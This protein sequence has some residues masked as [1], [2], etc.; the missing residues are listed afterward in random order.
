MVSAFAGC[1]R[2]C[3]P[4]RSSKSHRMLLVHWV[5]GPS[6]RDSGS[7]ARG[8]FLDNRCP[9]PIRNYFLWLLQLL[10]GDLSGARGVFCFALIMMGSAL[11]KIPCLMRLLRHLLLSAARHSFTFSAQLVPDVNTQLADALSRFH[12]QE[13]HL[14]AP[15]AQPCR[16]HFLHSY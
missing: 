12:W 6:S 16:F 5:L 3:P 15:D 13:L 14:L 11:S 9:L 1:F 10:C 2:V 8:L 7:M 4:L